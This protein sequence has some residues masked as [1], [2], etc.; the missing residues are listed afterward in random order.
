MRQ[1]TLTLALLGFALQALPAATTWYT[2][3]TGNN[4]AAGTDPGH[5][6]ATIQHGVD[7]LEPGDTLVILPGEYHE[8]IQRKDLGSDDTVTTI[9]AAIPGTAVIRGDVA[10]PDFQ[11]WPE[12]P[13]VYV[14]DFE[15]DVQAV[16]E[17]DTLSRL[18]RQV[19]PWELQFSPGSY[20]YDAKAGKLYISSSDLQPVATHH[21][22]VAVTPANG[23]LLENPRNVVIDG[24]VTTGF[25]SQD[26][27]RASPGHFAVW[28]IVL[29]A[30][31][32]CTVQNCTSYLNGGGIVVSA[33]GGGN[34]IADSVA[35]GNF[36]PHSE[37]GGNIVI[38][39]HTTGDSIRNCLSYLSRGYGIRL[40][41][42]SSG[43]ASIEDC[44][45]WGNAADFFVKG[46]NVAKY[47]V[48]RNTVAQGLG[49]ARNTESVY[50]G[51]QNIYQRPAESPDDTIRRQRENI[52]ENSEFADPVNF[53]FRL[54]STSKF[55]GA[56]ADGT[57][58]GPYP[59][60]A[61]VFF[62]NPQGNDNADG[63]SLSSAWQTFDRAAQDLRPGDTLYI[64]AGTYD[65][66]TALAIGKENAPSIRIVARGTD[67]VTLNGAPQLRDCHNLAFERIH[68]TGSPAIDGGSAITFRNCRFAGPAT[69]SADASTNLQIIH[70]SFTTTAG[71]ALKLNQCH[72]TVISSN[73]F[74]TGTTTAVAADTATTI[75]YSDYNAYSADKPW[76][77]GDT[78]LTLAELQPAQDNYSSQI[79][80]RRAGTVPD[81]ALLAGRGAAG[82][83][84][85]PYQDIIAKTL[86]MTAPEVYSVS[87]TTANIEWVISDRAIT[88]L[89]WGDTEACE[90]PVRFGA[91]AR[92]NRHGTFSLTGLEPNTTYYFRIRG[93]EFPAHERI[94]GIPEIVDPKFEVI[95]FTTAASDPT[96]RTLHVSPTG[97]DANSGLSAATPWRTIRHAAATAA[98]GDTVEIAAGT[99]SELVR[100][101]KTG[102]A[103]K[104]ITF[105]SA[106]GQR[107]VMESDNKRLSRSF[108]LTSKHHIHL[109]SLYMAAFQMGN[110]HVGALDLSDSNHVT[111]S[112]IF[113]DG[114]GYGYCSSFLSAVNCD[115]LKIS[116]CV[117]INGIYGI[118]I[119]GGSDMVIEHSLFLR[120]MIEATKISTRGENNVFRNNIVSDSGANKVGVWLHTWGSQDAI[121]DENNCYII[122][123]PDEERN[124]FWIM[125]FEEDG[126]T[127]GHTRMSIAE[128]NRRVHPT[129][130][131][132]A[133]P[134]FPAMEGVDL[135]DGFLGD[136]I[137][138]QQPLDFERLF[139]TNPDLVKRNIGLDPSQFED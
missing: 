86:H 15:G 100:M 49:H 109:D 61:T 81:S 135:A 92:S 22:R 88:S 70:C 99:Y 10:A 117:I 58:A 25:V 139:T 107:V 9:K 80:P 69:L 54:Q 97:D 103:G 128:Y 23:I 19:D 4:T 66:A 105:R 118:D 63:L 57:D 26:Q 11:P 71:P 130:S 65:A 29:N 32:D 124:L 108:V 56:T 79:N 3:P 30:A 6:F 16:I 94:L 132:V 77:V 64:E 76:R 52:D 2:S 89:A 125:S 47:T 17:V 27:R 126:K 72:D 134:G 31:R 104:P 110:W 85:G 28:G 93:F 45:A 127:L 35:Y 95:A 51:A 96:P 106:D 55:R 91:T 7:A 120:N 131:L 136:A 123:R 24:L 18:T 8:S 73:L 102:D 78:T 75:R 21:Y 111:I 53:D 74:S 113:F 133:D 129:N 62:L 98:P 87:A 5:A 59:F 90:N 112:R 84:I 67:I 40:Y 138:R 114:R 1:F 44:V 101:R 13:R 116:N 41:G 12:A 115:A 46:A 121:I 82:K 20:H 37:E 38:F 43:Y 34:T 14:A 60:D 50:I 83:P 42:N 48:V 36:S 39:G 33:S 68:F 137:V 122:R 119:R